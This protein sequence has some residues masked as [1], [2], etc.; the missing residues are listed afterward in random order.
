MEIM[1]SR[2]PLSDGYVLSTIRV[3]P[4]IPLPRFLNQTIILDSRPETLALSE[5]NALLAL[6][7]LGTRQLCF[8]P[9]FPDPWNDPTWREGKRTFHCTF[10]E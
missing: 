1:I 10:L 3:P 4:E 6:R 9:D 2:K 8:G 7:D 5:Q